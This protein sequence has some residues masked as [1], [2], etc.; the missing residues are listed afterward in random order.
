M[1]AR[2]ELNEIEGP[3]SDRL[4]HGI[5]NSLKS[6]ICVIGLDGHV[7]H[8]NDAWRGFASA[9]LGSEEACGV[10][11][12]YF[13]VCLRSAECG[14]EYAM[15]VVL[16]IQS[17]IRG[18]QNSFQ[19]EYPCHSPIEPRW[20][21][22]RVTKSVDEEG[23][24]L[25]IAHDNITQR[26]LAELEVQRAKV[27]I[28]AMNRKL[29]KALDREKMLART[30]VLTG[31]SNRRHFYDIAE[32]ELA[33]AKRYHQ[34]LSVVLFDVDNFKLINDELG[35][36]MGDEILR[37]VAQVSLRTVRRAD[38]VAR[39]GGEEFVVLLPNTT[40]D[41]AKVV[42][43]R[44]RAQIAS[45]QYGEAEHSRQITVSAGIAVLTHSDE[46]IDSLIR[47]ADESLYQAKRLGRDR[48]IIQMPPAV[49]EPTER[50]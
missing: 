36:Q 27:E 47:R 7:L 1:R 32:H 21:I 31:L 13:E 30:D 44:I 5:L 12:N 48:A 23:G 3:I 22:M 28:E 10:G 41:H 25:V 14:D 4:A 33:V 15:Q 17:V 8:V 26:K 49:P 11:T 50:S 9:N 29:Q 37:M 2:K 42:A 43:E 38:L 24:Y 16:G 45:H 6:H 34:A 18:D 39:Y 20:Y 46:T 35:H 19:I 40:G